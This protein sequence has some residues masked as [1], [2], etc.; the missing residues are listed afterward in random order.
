ML[1]NAFACLHGPEEESRGEALVKVQGLDG[2]K[3][4]Q[5][6]AGAE[7]SALVIG[8]YVVSFNIIC[9]ILFLFFVMSFIHFNLLFSFSLS[10]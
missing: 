2:S 5:I 1:A 4:V 7:H 9:S 6:A 8:K 10:L 3:V